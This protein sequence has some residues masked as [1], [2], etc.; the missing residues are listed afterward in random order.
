M[1]NAVLVESD[2]ERGMT[3]KG[4]DDPKGKKRKGKSERAKGV[5]RRI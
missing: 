1:E 3:R 2:P 4:S 5:K